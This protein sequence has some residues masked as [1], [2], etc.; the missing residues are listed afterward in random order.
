MTSWLTGRD[1]VTTYQ[2]YRGRWLTG[3][4]MSYADFRSTCAAGYATY[5]RVRQTATQSNS[6]RHCGNHEYGDVADFAKPVDPVVVYIR[7]AG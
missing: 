6:H 1:D 5:N 3:D 7:A 4:E 2:T